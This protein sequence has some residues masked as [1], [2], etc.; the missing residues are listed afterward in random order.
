MRPDTVARWASLTLVAACSGAGDDLPTAD[1]TDGSSPAPNDSGL[2]VPQ[3]TA[4]PAAVAWTVDG[5]FTV[6]PGDVALDV[7]AYDEGG[8]VRCALSGVTASVTP[9]DAV[10]DGTP[11][12]VRL[13]ALP[14]LD[15]AP[16]LPDA[17]TLRLAPLS[18][19]LAP[20][21]DRWGVGEIP[22]LGVEVE[23]DGAWRAYGVLRA[24]PVIGQA[25]VRWPEGGYVFS[26][27][28]ALALDPDV[29][30]EV[31]SAER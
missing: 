5:V 13:G 3:D 19:D 24:G 27:A 17:L 6:G 10:G 16:S 4:L 7:V 20:A 26:A 30:D 11:A 1:V 21:A 8:V 2:P 18:I 12:T 31:G 9:S 14:A 25:P 15:C 28:Y 23:V 22:G 29:S